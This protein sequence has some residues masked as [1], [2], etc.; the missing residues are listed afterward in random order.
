MSDPSQLRVADDERQ[1]L[2]DGPAPDED[3]VEARLAAGR[4]R[5]VAR[6]GRHSSRRD[7]LR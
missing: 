3:A 1:Q 6:E 4:R 2:V 5:Q 7:L